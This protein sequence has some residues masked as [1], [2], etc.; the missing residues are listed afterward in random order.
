MVY[1]VDLLHP[2]MGEPNPE[3]FVDHLDLDISSDV[4]GV[5]V[6][7]TT[8]IVLP[9]SAILF[10]ENLFGKHTEFGVN[11]NLID[12]T[13]MFITKIDS[14]QSKKRPRDAFDLYVALKSGEIDFST[15][16]RIRKENSEINQ[17][18]NRLS[19]YLQKNNESFNQ[20]VSRYAN[21]STIESAAFELK[22]A[23]DKPH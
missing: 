15:I 6:K 5:G 22:D 7:A 23:I 9:N 8:S 20:N 10:S 11:F 3:M 13:G 2:T 16:A 18:L 14:C 12:F 4:N 21:G 17:A 19:T 1:N